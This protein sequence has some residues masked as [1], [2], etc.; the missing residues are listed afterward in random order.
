MK[1]KGFIRRAKRRVSLLLI[2]MMMMTMMPMLTG[3]GVDNSSIN[4]AIINSVLAKHIFAK[5]QEQVSLIINLK[6][7]H[8]IPDVMADG[9]LRELEAAIKGIEQIYV[10]TIEYTSDASTDSDDE[11]DEDDEE[12][13]AI[14]IEADAGRHEYIERVIASICGLGGYPTVYAE[15]VKV[16]SNKIS[17]GELDK[18]NEYSGYYGSFINVYKGFVTE[19]IIKHSNYRSV[20]NMN[21]PRPLELFGST[22]EVKKSSGSLPTS[23]KG[24]VDYLNGLHDM[25]V[26]YLNPSHADSTAKLANIKDKIQQAMGGDTNALK[27]LIGGGIFAKAGVKV[28]ISASPLSESTIYRV[29][30]FDVDDVRSQPINKPWEELKVVQA[31]APKAVSYQIKLLN[32]TAIEN[33]FKVGEKDID[34]S[35]GVRI[36][37]VFL[38]TRYPLAVFRGV[39]QDP[40]DSSKYLPVFFPTE[41][42]CYYPSIKGSSFS[43][44][45]GSLTENYDT[46]GGKGTAENKAAYVD[47]FTGEMYFKDG[48]RNV[49]QSFMGIGSRDLEASFVVKPATSVYTVKDSGKYNDALIT[50]VSHTGGTEYN[51]IDRVEIGV[52]IVDVCKDTVGNMPVFFLTD[53]LE[54]IYSP[55]TVGYDAFTAYGRK[56]KL[57]EKIVLGKDAITADTGSIAYIVGDGATVDDWNKRTAVYPSI[58]VEDLMDIDGFYTYS[59]GFQAK[60]KEE[61]TSA[62]NGTSVVRLIKSG[63]QF[64]AAGTIHSGDVTAERSDML[65]QIAA[66]KSVEC[67]MRFGA[68]GLDE[69][70]E[71]VRKKTPL[72]GILVRGNVYERQLLTDW[73]LAS[74][75]ANLIKWEK[76]I[77][78]LGYPNYKISNALLDEK[79]KGNYAFELNQDGLLTLDLDTILEINKEYEE[80]R[81]G[82]ALVYLRTLLL[83]LGFV[84]IAYVSVLIGAWVAD[85]NFDL[86]LNLLHKVSI[87]H[88]V[89]VRSLDEMPEADP[90]SKTAYVDFRKLLVRCFVFAAVGVII[91]T[92]DPVNL[93]IKIMTWLS[94]V[95]NFLS[96]KLFGVKVF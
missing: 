27:E 20:F 19:N 15:P 35:A 34:L 82:G 8:I 88:F 74:G 23:I 80:E 50:T 6:E 14:T 71:G 76:T 47:I 39:V 84:L 40:S 16:A 66:Q 60:T 46:T 70:D 41:S 58:G 52:K 11:D 18:A 86:G 64:E 92:V 17:K 9:L 83:V 61:G 94:F 22:E 67:V 63:Q 53:Y 59:S 43:G 95:I 36:G 68:S 89:A 31:V 51:P 87:G 65:P 57:D 12:D 45:A 54:L 5:I 38:V 1:F 72:Y 30:T 25:D 33:A 96:E 3:C 42:V 81:R 85:V 78:D 7:R 93:V 91:L 44:T 73:I 13:I 75:N 79:L 37:N 77:A 48:E 10:G 21:D 4:A 2:I 32:K 90:E 29:E 24:L 56:V 69:G 62:E 55:D 49:A 26:Y 28:N